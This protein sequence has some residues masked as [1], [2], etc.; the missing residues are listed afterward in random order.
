MKHIVDDNKDNDT[1]FNIDKNFLK[2]IINIINNNNNKLKNGAKKK[3]K[4]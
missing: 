2:G 1:S 3:I 4:K